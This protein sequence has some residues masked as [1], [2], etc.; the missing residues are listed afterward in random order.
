MSVP[1]DAKI[2]ERWATLGRLSLI[3]LL[4]SVHR[5]CSERCCAAFPAAT[6]RNRNVIATRNPAAT[7]APT[8]I[9]GRMGHATCPGGVDPDPRPRPRGLRFSGTGIR[10]S[11]GAP[12]GPATGYRGRVVLGRRWGG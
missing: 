3:G 8:S 12:V 11:Y 10:T 6:T 9:T 7:T 1:S 5:S 2:D 4:F